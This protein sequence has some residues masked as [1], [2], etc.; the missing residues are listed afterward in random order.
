MK[1]NNQNYLIEYI[2]KSIFNLERTNWKIE[3]SWV[4]V[5]VG[6]HGNELSDRLGEEAACSTECPVVF[7]RI[8]K[9][10]LCSELEKGPTQKWQEKWEQCK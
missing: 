1:A 9:S 5:H 2:R 7:D 10:N 3:F 4:K 6:I 8:P